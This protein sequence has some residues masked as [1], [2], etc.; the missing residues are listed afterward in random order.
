MDD[1]PKLFDVIVYQAEWPGPGMDLGV[2][3]GGEPGGWR[4]WTRSWGAEPWFETTA[5]KVFLPA[6]HRRREPH[7]KSTVAEADRLRELAKDGGNHGE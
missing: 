1:E 3:I 6:E 2:L 4:I 7:W 5:G